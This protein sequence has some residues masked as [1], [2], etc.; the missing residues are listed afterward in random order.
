MLR[1]LPQGF[2]LKCWRLEIRSW[3]SS[4]FSPGLEGSE[5]QMNDEPMGLHPR[6][7]DPMLP[8]RRK[9]FPIFTSRPNL[10]KPLNFL[11]PKCEDVIGGWGRIVRKAVLGERDRRSNL[12][13]VSLWSGISG[14]FTK[15]LY[16]E[17]QQVL[18][19]SYHSQYIKRSLDLFFLRPSLIQ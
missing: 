8:S 5:G 11:Y 2:S 17:S 10:R 16:S 19:L 12:F 4:S 6:S 14:S 13:C 18:L 1:S 15:G 9:V 7:P 3:E